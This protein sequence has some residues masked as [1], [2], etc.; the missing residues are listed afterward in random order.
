M[1]KYLNISTGKL[2]Q[3]EDQEEE[4]VEEISEEKNTAKEVRNDKA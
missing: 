4:E 1:K 2:V 3:D